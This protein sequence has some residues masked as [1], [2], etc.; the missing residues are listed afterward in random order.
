M[1]RCFPY[2]PPGYA[3]KC[4]SNEALIM[5][6]KLRRENEKANS[7]KKK[8]KKREKKEK[9]DER[10]EQR[11]AKVTAD[12]EK[13]LVDSR[14]AQDDP[15]GES[16]YKLE[17]LE[18]SNLT[19]EHGRPCNSSESTENSAKRKRDA[20]SST[21]IQNHGKIIRIRLS[22]QKRDDPATIP[23]PSIGKGTL[24][25]QEC[26]SSLVHA[27]NLPNPPAMSTTALDVEK[28]D[29][30]LPSPA[31]MST[32]ADHRDFKSGNKALLPLPERIEMQTPTH[33]P[34]TSRL[35][36]KK[37]QKM[38]A[39]HRDMPLSDKVYPRL[40]ERNET[41]THSHAISRSEDKKQQNTETK[42]TDPLPLLPDLAMPCHAPSTSRSH[43]KKM[44]KKLG[45]Y[46]DLVDK[47]VPPPLQSVP[48]GDDDDD[49]LF[50]GRNRMERDNGA[51]KRLKV[52]ENNL[53]SC[54]SYA[55]QPRAV[56]L[57][58]VGIYAL[59]YTVPF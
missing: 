8:E 50:A 4:A 28:I 36:A 15:K 25:Q 2:P 6:I 14:P 51:A 43:D 42:C 49:W 47:W 34:S 12:S 37:M 24:A 54:G 58:D 59:P 31:A 53:A 33:T 13:E 10:R 26:R 39:E 46:I 11:K 56:Y 38:D 9:K 48:T 22:S 40:S 7:G 35:Q 44:R 16:K 17:L 18:K 5:S 21:I 41:S 32:A 29:K 20:E 1:S 27:H 55:L 52:E 45:K 57:A 30:P 19:V 3:G 23:S